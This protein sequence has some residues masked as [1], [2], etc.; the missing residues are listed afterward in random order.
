[1]VACT[2]ARL[3]LQ[4]LQCNAELLPRVVLD[5]ESE[6]ELETCRIEAS[7]FE[8]ATLKPCFE[9]VGLRLMAHRLY[10]TNE[11]LGTTYFLFDCESAHGPITYIT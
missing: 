1:V 5:C 9:L 7:Q 10:G 8:F 6:L 3:V 2:R 11:K 4:A